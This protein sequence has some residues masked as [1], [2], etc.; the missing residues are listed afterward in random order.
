M[1]RLGNMPRAERRGFIKIEAEMNAAFYFRE[2]RLKMKIRG[3]VIGRISAQDDQALHPAGINIIRESAQ[4]VQLIHR[5]CFN[6][7]SK[8]NG[9]TNV[10]EM[11]IEKMGQRVDL[12]R[13]GFSDND[14]AFPA[15]FLE[16]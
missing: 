15:T 9:L 8:E 14:D 12:G 3:G 11:V 10:S 1:V 4:G 2:Q 7:F 13:L 6:R 5:L 16:V